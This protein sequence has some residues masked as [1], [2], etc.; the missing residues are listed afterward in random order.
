M[1]INFYRQ[2]DRVFCR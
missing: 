1:K 2:S